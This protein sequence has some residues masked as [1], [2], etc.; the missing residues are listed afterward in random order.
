MDELGRGWTRRQKAWA[1]HVA[2]LVLL[3]GAIAVWPL[4][5]PLAGT[6][7]VILVVLL[8]AY[9]LV[10]TLAVPLASRHRFGVAVVHAVLLLVGASGAAILA[11]AA[12]GD[13]ARLRAIE[14]SRHQ[15]EERRRAEEAPRRR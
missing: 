4:T 6:A 8:A 7:R 2:V 15:T 14:A 13:E 11:R 10:T 5:G 1:G 12:R 3:L 9:A